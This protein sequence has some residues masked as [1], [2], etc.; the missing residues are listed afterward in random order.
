[1]AGHR[2]P[3]TVLGIEPGAHPAEYRHGLVLCRADQ[4]VVWRGDRLPP[5]VSPLIG[6]L[7]G[8]PAP[9]CSG[10][11]RNRSSEAATGLW[12]PTGR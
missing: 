2:V 7:R 12:D 3:L 9:A 1:M 8:I 11:L 6:L 5:D 10:Q 4:H